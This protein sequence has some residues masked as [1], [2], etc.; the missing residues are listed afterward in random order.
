MKWQDVAKILVSLSSIGVITLFSALFLLTNIDYTFTPDSVCNELTCV[1]YIN[2][3]TT[4]WR[5]CFAGYDGTKYSDEILFKKQTRSRTLHVNLDKVDN[6]IQTDPPIPVDWLVPARGKGNWR[7]IKDGDCW[8]RP[9]TRAINR[10]KLIGHPAEG[11]I[12]KWSFNLEDKVNI[13][14]IWVSWNIEYENL[15]DEVPVYE[16]VIETFPCDEKNTSCKGY[17]NRTKKVLTGYKTEYYKGEKIGVRVG[18]KSYDKNTNVKGDILVQWHFNIEGRNFLE[19]G[20]CFS[21]E[22]AKGK[23]KETKILEAIII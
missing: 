6:I 12:T 22:E 9:S 17:R 4:Y 11:Q 5:V 16:W 23:C 20:D 19:F 15:S 10:I 1:A 18:D 14:P 13:D 2:V 7:P 3:T 21:Y 8:E